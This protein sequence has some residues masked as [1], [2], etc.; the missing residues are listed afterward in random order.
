[1]QHSPGVTKL[2]FVPRLDACGARRL[3]GSFTSQAESPNSH[4]LC[5]SL[6]SEPVPEAV[7]IYQHSLDQ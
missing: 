2:I 7:Y 4:C 5:S 1:M 3:R 6:R